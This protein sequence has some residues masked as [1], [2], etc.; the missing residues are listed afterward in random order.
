MNKIFMVL[1]YSSTHVTTVISYETM[2]LKFDVPG[3]CGLVRV[4]SFYGYLPLQRSCHKKS[5]LISQMQLTFHFRI[6]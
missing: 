1:V 6:S 3:H 5:I 2:V 4:T